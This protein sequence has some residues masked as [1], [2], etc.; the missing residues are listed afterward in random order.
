MAIWEN[1][2]GTTKTS[3]GVG[4]TGPKLKQSGNNLLVRN[5]ADGADSEITASKVNISGESFVLNSDAAGAGADWTYTF[6]RPTSGMTAAVSLTLPV[7][8][9]TAGQVLSTDGAGVLSWV[10]SGSTS[11]LTARDTTTVAFGTSSP[12]TMFTLPANAVLEKVQVIIDTAFDTAATVTVGI[13]GTTSKYSGTSDVN[14]QATAESV[15]T[16]FSGK[17]PSGST[18][19]IIATYVAS[20]ASAGSARV[21]VDYSVPQ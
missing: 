5:N 7:D 2:D 3:F 20:G 17:S 11:H 4:L 6:L 12:V 10:S 14:L 8:D 18:E 21:I 16:V 1:Q 15:F 13:V 9:G 19:A